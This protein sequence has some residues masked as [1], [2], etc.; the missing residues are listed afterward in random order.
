MEVTKSRTWFLPTKN[1]DS[2][3]EISLFNR[4]FNDSYVTNIRT[5]IWYPVGVMVVRT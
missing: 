3:S 1:N 2:E 5:L 4:I